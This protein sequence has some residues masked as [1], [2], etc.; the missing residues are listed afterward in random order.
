MKNEIVNMETKAIASFQ[1]AIENALV[2]VTS[3]EPLEFSVN[4]CEN[5]HAYREE[6]FDLRNAALE[7]CAFLIQDREAHRGKIKVLTSQLL[8]ARGDIFLDKDDSHPRRPNLCV[9]EDGKCRR[10]QD[11]DLREALE[12]Y[13]SEQLES[14]DLV[15]EVLRPEEPDP[16]F[17]FRFTGGRMEFIRFVRGLF[18][19]DKIVPVGGAKMIHCVR[20]L[21]RLFHVPE[22]RNL[23]NA[24]Y[25]MVCTGNQLRFFDNFRRDLEKQVLAGK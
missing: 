20:Y 5:L 12:D 7:E 9:L 10:R 14:I 4:G 3:R 17:P 19:T 8:H 16:D 15:L 24:I 25:R 23:S 11:D 18:I 21:L 22:G 1:R 2:C 13:V 6:L